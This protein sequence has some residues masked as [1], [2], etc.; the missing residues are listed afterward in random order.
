MSIPIR[1]VLTSGTVV[2]T[3]RPDPHWRAARALLGEEWYESYTYRIERV[4]EGRNIFFF[5][6]TLTT[7][8]KGE[9]PRYVYT[10]VIHPTLGTLRMTAK[11]AFPDTA[12]RVRV[13]R[14]VFEAIF[15]GNGAA[16]EAANWTVTALVEKELAGRF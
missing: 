9:N 5:L 2:V 8:R 6:H 11:S 1:S 15:K 7:N 4:E 10:G 16:V 14:R 3:V 13:A 12:T